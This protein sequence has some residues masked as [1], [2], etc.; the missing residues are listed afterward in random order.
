MANEY[1]KI[2]E[3][4]NEYIE[5]AKDV[6]GQELIDELRKVLTENA[7]LLEIGSGPGTDWNLLSKHYQVTGSDF[8]SEFIKHLKNKFP[9]GE[10]LELDATTLNTTHKFDGIY[11]NKV[12]HHLN[13]EQLT[14]SIARQAEILKTGG[15][16]CFSFW[17]GEGSE[18]FKGMFV[19]YHTDSDLRKFFESH[20]EILSI[21]FYE[22]FE[23]NDSLLLIAKR[24]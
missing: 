3:S 13:D 9:D 21:S 14:Q 24:K 18:T 7:L 19:N 16:I 17:K 10:F 23:A 8:S 12:L 15:I 11:A 5:S 1:Y 4:V 22:E 20:F 2:K 6:N